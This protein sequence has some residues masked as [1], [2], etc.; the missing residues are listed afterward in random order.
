MGLTT[1]VAIFVLL[2]NFL[3]DV[4]YTVANPRIRYQ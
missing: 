2:A 3:A 1:F 4:A